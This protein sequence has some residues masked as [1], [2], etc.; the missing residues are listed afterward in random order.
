MVDQ[1]AERVDETGVDFKHLLHTGKQELT[2]TQALL[3]GVLAA[4]GAVLIGER[5]AAVC[6]DFVVLLGWS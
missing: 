4:V 3:P 1:L 2:Q 6:A 5:R